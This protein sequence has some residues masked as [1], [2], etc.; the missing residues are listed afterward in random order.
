MTLKWSC[1]LEVQLA[2]LVF[3]EEQV[4]ACGQLEV[5]L[6]STAWKTPERPT[7]TAAGST[8]ALA[9]SNELNCLVTSRSLC[10]TLRLL[11]DQDN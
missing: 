5:Q 7:T 11:E 2:Q 10:L 6:E 9:I 8:A 1:L 4:C 3:H